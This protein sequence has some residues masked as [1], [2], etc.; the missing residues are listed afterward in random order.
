M[1]KKPVVQRPPTENCITLQ[2]DYTSLISPLKQDSFE[3]NSTEPNHSSS[4]SSEVTSDQSAED[5]LNRINNKHSTFEALFS[6][7]QKKK[8]YRAI[9]SLLQKGKKP[10]F[11][12][13][14]IQKEVKHGKNDIRTI[15]VSFISQVLTEIE[16]ATGLTLQ[17]KPNLPIKYIDSSNWTNPQN[18]SLNAETE[19]KLS[20]LKAKLT[21]DQEKRAFD[22]I[23]S[24]MRA[25]HESISQKMVKDAIYEQFE[26]H[27]N[28][29]Y[30]SSVLGKI[31]EA[32]NTQLRRYKTS[33]E[34][35]RLK[36]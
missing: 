18:S 11:S 20:S 31:E 6:Q 2:I 30:I 34:L 35:E 24:L 28:T 36:S 12:Q 25:G 21:K 8:A 3:T 23:V 17:N 19:K 10:P 5:I 1:R 32:L 9:C 27:E 4:P 22:A 13:R 29:Q 26:V 16:K 15:N 14:A 33:N 7:S